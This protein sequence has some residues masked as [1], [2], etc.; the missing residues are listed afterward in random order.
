LDG[1]EIG[2]IRRG[3]ELLFATAEPD[4]HSAAGAALLFLVMISSRA[5]ATGKLEFSR[6][7]R[8]RKRKCRTI[9]ERNQE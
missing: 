1:C 5:L 9:R 4:C 3:F 8:A 7:V 6:R 2:L